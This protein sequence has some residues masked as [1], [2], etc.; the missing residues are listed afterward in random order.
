M[1]LESS[2]PMTIRAIGSDIVKTEDLSPRERARRLNVLNKRG[3]LVIDEE[4]QGGMNV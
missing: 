1:P 4:M 2:D 3:M